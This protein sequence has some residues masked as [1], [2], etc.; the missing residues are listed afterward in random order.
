MKVILILT[1]ALII[2][3]CNKK[4]E[5][6][7]NNTEVSSVKPKTSKSSVTNKD[8]A[9]ENIKKV[10]KKFDIEKKCSICHDLPK[11]AEK[12]KDYLDKKLNFHRKE[13]RITLRQEEFESLKKRILSKAKK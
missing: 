5:T 9:K 8:K 1:L 7:G 10:V 3:S 6:K 2:A 13:R 4:Q 11:F 12:E